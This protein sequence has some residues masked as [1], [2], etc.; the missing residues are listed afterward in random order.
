MLVVMSG[1]VKSVIMS[2]KYVLSDKNAPDSLVNVCVHRQV[3]AQKSAA[4]KKGYA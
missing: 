2:C 3:D 4:K 1:C